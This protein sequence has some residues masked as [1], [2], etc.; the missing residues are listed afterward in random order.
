LDLGISGKTALVVGGSRG[1][2]MAVSHMLFD[3]GAYVTSVGRGPFITERHDT[4]TSIFL[5]LMQEGA[6]DELVDSVD[7]P[8]IIYYCI[9][10]SY[11]DIKQWDA[12]AEDSQKVWQFIL[13][14]AV[15]LNR[16]FVPHMLEKKW[17]RVVMTSTDGTKCNSGNAP[18][19]SAK[20]ALEGYVKTVSK[21]W[22]K[23]NVI[24]TAVAPG[25]V[26][27]PGRFMY[28]QGKE[29]T[30]EYMKH[31]APIGRWAS[32]EEIA[33]VVTFLCSDGASYM[34]GA[35]VRCDGGSR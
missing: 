34:S 30:D 26:Y 5:D 6:I 18:Y 13:G 17:G 4:H 24:L 10:G 27:T 29:W 12:S 22:A 11:G 14:I 16:H 9:G 8:D 3:A 1:V 20:F 31:H 2:G 35:I 25:H 19:T 7:E 33:K 15:E 23:D 32:D 28:E 21:I